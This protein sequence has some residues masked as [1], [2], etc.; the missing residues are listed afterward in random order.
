MN[1]PE[2]L[3]KI[4]CSTMSIE[5][6]QTLLDPLQETL[7]A[8]QNLLRSK[9]KKK[10][11]SSTL[12]ADFLTLRE[13]TWFGA[14][15]SLVNLHVISYITFEESIA[16]FDYIFTTRFVHESQ[17][18]PMCLGVLNLLVKTNESL[19]HGQFLNTIREFDEIR[20]FFDEKY[21]FELE[22]YILS[23][24]KLDI[25]ISTP[26]SFLE[27]YE[28][29]FC[30]LESSGLISDEEQRDEQVLEIYMTT[31]SFLLELCSRVYSLS[32]YPADVLAAAILMISRE[33]SGFEII[34]PSQIEDFSGFSVK[35]P[36]IDHLKF[37]MMHYFYSSRDSL[38][39]ELEEMKINGMIQ[40]KFFNDMKKKV[41]NLKF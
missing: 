12:S 7:Y 3:K 39:Y 38:F 37:E 16:V 2:N 18:L 15:I 10:T 22:G 24:F 31:K 23:V 9:M 14:L 35:D 32:I 8:K 41:N 4:N 36:N 28:Q 11:V 19:K 5:T 40:K 29:K 34:W 6:R 20:P 30:E 17:I 25:K 26:A 27:V 13:K 33:R 21:L 1:Q